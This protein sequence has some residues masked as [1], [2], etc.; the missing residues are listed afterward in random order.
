MQ[1]LLAS[2]SSIFSGAVSSYGYIGIAVL[3]FFETANIPVPSE[4]IMPFAGFLANKGELVVWLVLA[5]GVAGNV[6]GA[7]TS[8]SIAGRIDHNLHEKPAYR[9]ANG[10]FKKYGEFS[11]FF[12]QLV[13]IVRTFISFPAGMFKMNIVKFAVLT[14]LGSIIWS[15]A[16]TYIGWL[17]GDKWDV[18]EPIFNKFNV[19]IVV[20]I[21]LGA[22]FFVWYHYKQNKNHEDGYSKL[23]K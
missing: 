11:V 13:P 1:N 10:W 6:A 20:L 22:G 7:F 15:S 2:F 14:S 19:I 17:F 23:E 8:Y 12:G 4:I 16:L 18:L 3:M 21:V 5:A 9:L